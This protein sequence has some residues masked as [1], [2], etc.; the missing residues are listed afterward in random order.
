[1]LIERHLIR[2]VAAAPEPVAV[3][4]LIDGNPIDP[5]AQARLTSEPVNCGKDAQED[6]LG[7][8]QRL[9][10][11]AQQ[12]GGELDDHPLVFSHQLGAGRFLADC[13]PLHEGRFAAA[14]V[15]PTDDTRLLHCKIPG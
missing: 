6:F 12:V 4:S 10:A 14:D 5:G 9:L 1:M 11:I 7:E 2:P 3:P 13:T 8:I 15:E